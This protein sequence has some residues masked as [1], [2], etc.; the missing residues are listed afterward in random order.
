MQYNRQPSL[1]STDRTPSLPRTGAQSRAKQMHNPNI[2]NAAWM[3][4]PDAG[5]SGLVNLFIFIYF[6]YLPPIFD[7]PFR[8]HGGWE[9]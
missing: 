3:K 4:T 6:Y 7:F 1:A 9:K 2:H 8:K 5:V